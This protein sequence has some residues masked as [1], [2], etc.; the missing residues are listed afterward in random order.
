M[1]IDHIINSSNLVQV[2]SIDQLKKILKDQIR[3]KA[4]EGELYLSEYISQGINQIELIQLC[5]ELKKSGYKVKIKA[6]IQDTLFSI[7]WN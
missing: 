6:T 2:H 1:F 7:F 4:D 5:E 3:L